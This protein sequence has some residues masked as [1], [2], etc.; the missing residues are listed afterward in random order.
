MGMVASAMRCGFP[1]MKLAATATE[2]KTLHHCF[3]FSVEVKTWNELENENLASWEK[4][5]VFLPWGRA[6]FVREICPTAE[7]KLEKL[8]NT[9][10]SGFGL[11]FVFFF[12]S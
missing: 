1:R 8:G 6:A 3:C 10:K 2:K 9:L 12:I 11:L 4:L 5:R 7:G